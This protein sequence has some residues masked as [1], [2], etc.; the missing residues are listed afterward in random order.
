MEADEDNILSRDTYS[1]KIEQ[2]IRTIISLRNLIYSIYS[3]DNFVK[4][5]EKIIQSLFEIEHTLHDSCLFIHKNYIKIKQT[6]EL[7][8]L[9]KDNVVM[10]ESPNRMKKS[11]DSKEND[12]FELSYNQPIT[13]KGKDKSCFIEESN[14]IKESIVKKNQLTTMTYPLSTE[15][16]NY[17]D[18]STNIKETNKPNA[19]DV[20]SYHNAKDYLRSKQKDNYKSLGTFKCNQNKIEQYDYHSDHHSDLSSMPQTSIK[21]VKTPLIKINQPNSHINTSTIGVE[22]VNQNHSLTTIDN[23]PNIKNPND[24]SINNNG[25][26]KKN[27]SKVADIIMKLNTKEI[28]FNI[29]LQLFGDNVLDQLME[30]PP[31]EPII[32]AVEKSIGEL[33]RLEQ[34][35]KQKELLHINNIKK[36]IQQSN[37]PLP[38]NTKDFNKSQSLKRNQ[39]NQNNQSCS[40]VHTRKS[41]QSLHDS[42]TL[43]VN[44]KITYADDLLA[45]ISCKPKKKNNPKKYPSY[46][47]LYSLNSSSYIDI[48]ST[49]AKFKLPIRHNKNSLS[50]NIKNSKKELTN[51]KQFNNCLFKKLT[52]NA[53]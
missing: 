16:D 26:I 13:F 19:Y 39:R 6:L 24:F 22:E 18:K 45:Y 50:T 12:Y 9:G 35:D 49:E 17:D 41:N 28:L 37:L 47:K 1:I 43:T 44:K 15:K 27:A 46:T 53:G 36:E 4:E 7:N 40:F 23:N 29:I 2:E 48:S 31:N 5:K 34:E 38:N 21:L 20:E 52:S 33:E 10:I 14:N 25:L 30:T 32:E 11:N 8:T 51:T 42:L 3:Y